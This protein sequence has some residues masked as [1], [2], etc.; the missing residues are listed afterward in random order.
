MGIPLVIMRFGLLVILW[1]AWCALHS[2]LV[3][4]LVTEPLRK[5]FP[6]GFRYYRLFYNFLAV[7]ALAP[8]LLYSF[9]LRGEPLVAW[10]GPWRIVP[11][12]LGVAAL[13]FFVAGGRRYDFSQLIGLRQI[14]EENTCSVLTD[15]CS[16]DTRGILSVVRHPWYS[17][18]ML[19]VWVRPLDVAA[20]LTNVVICGYLVVG[21]VL[22]ERKL[23]RQFGPEYAAYQQRVS[24][25]FPLKW[26]KGRF[27]RDH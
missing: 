4:P 17:G 10:E 23:G 7:V 15:D 25:F 13:F 1:I 6:K 20:V 18:G 14:R 9:S 22:E 27:L 19:V 21:A 26:L 16:L 3:S 2:V 24:M 11:I 8:V 12:L 5:R